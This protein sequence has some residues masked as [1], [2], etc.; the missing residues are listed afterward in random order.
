[1]FEEAA[2]PSAEA[3]DL[4]YFTLVKSNTAGVAPEDIERFLDPRERRATRRAVIA[5]EV[6]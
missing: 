5:K 3:V 2:S 4:F 1:V 6:E